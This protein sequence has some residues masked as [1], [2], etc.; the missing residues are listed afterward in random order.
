M[1]RITTL[2]LLCVALATQA[3]DTLQVVSKITDVTVFFYGANVSRTADLALD[4]G[5]HVI[6]IPDL[7]TRLH[8]STVQMKLPAG[9]NLVSMQ[10]MGHPAG[11]KQAATKSKVERD[12]LHQLKK[13]AGDIERIDIQIEALQLEEQMLRA[14]S[15]LLAK[16][17]GTSLQEI[18][19]GADYLRTRLAANRLERLEHQER[20]DAL[21]RQHSDFTKE[22]MRYRQRQLPS[23]GELLLKL[24][25][26]TFVKE[27][28]TF[29][30]FVESAAWVPSY[31][32]KVDDTAQPMS[33]IYKAEVSQSTGEDWS[34]INLTL[35]AS[36][37]TEVRQ[38]TERLRWDVAQGSPYR[39]D[40]FRIT[41]GGHAVL[42]GV[43]RDAASGDPL[44]FSN[45]IL[46]QNESVVGGATTDI[47]GRF[48]IRPVTPG[49]YDIECR[50]VGFNAHIRK[51]TRVNEGLLELEIDLTPGVELSEV[52]IVSYN[53]PLASKDGAASN[54]T[55]T[56]EDISRIPG[57]E[58]SSMAQT[59]A[60]VAS[61]GTG[62]IS[63]RGSRS[64]DQWVYIDGVKVR[65]SSQLPRSAM[66][67]PL[68]AYSPSEP[69]LSNA[70]IAENIR[71][72]K[73][74]SLGH[75]EY[76]LDQAYTIRSNGEAQ[77]LRVRDARVEVDYR[78]VVTPVADPAVFL[79]ARFS[80]W[81]TLNLLP[82]KV[83]MVY[84]NIYKGQVV[85][86]PA[87]FSDTLIVSLGQD[88]EVLVKREENR[89]KSERKVFSSGVREHI[90][91]TVS[92]RNTKPIAIR[93]EVQDQIPV[94]SNRSVSVELLESSEAVYDTD[95]GFLTWVIDVSPNTGREL[96]FAYSVRT[97]R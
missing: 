6:R 95:N 85:M 4:K 88:H 18:R 8:P 72:D 38:S 67:S 93:L 34:K 69:T 68:N 36:N 9:V 15:D 21:F 37:P 74:Q 66:D 46:R 76:V 31:D 42:S 41:T 84:Q 35:S 78:Y 65:G 56:R 20:R 11:A 59:V 19:E 3:S 32:F 27:P 43:V 53:M 12:L 89:M 64:S 96:D 57:R 47:D 40:E 63:I 94:S 45:I 58:A 39:A 55:V 81:E 71:G 2:L 90:G 77:T 1:K 87:Q 5:S 62:G 80:G 91:Y 83:N 30:Y 70:L 16:P 49:L 92:V 24:E 23:G 52:Q 86:D 82:G 97:P 54:R 51:N 79:H 13:L 50:Y 48:I 17:N 7:I 33:I 44:P 25:C 75:V 22:L 73:R 60:G 29:S 14:N 28:L 26:E 10:Y 61:A